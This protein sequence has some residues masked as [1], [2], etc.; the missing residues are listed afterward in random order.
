MSTIR[1]FLSMAYWLWWPIV[2][3]AGVIAAAWLGLRTEYWAGF[4]FGLFAALI[5][6]RWASWAADGFKS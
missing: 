5:T 3:C 4:T 6:R 1:F 2:F